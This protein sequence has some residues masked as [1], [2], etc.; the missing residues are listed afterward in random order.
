MK[1]PVAFRCVLMAATFIGA[2]VMMALFET[3]PAIV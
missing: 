3:T 2:T 1:R